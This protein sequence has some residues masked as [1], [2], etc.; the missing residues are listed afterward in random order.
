VW[1]YIRALGVTQLALI[2]QVHNLTDLAIGKAGDL[3]LAMGVHE[4]K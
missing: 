4:F 1:R 3:L 2:A